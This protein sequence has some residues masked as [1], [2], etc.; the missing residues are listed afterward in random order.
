MVRYLHV[1]GH[2]QVS[3]EAKTGE[4]SVEGSGRSLK[5]SHRKSKSG[6]VRTWSD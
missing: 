2:K 6:Q 3:Q 5:D 4:K 1:T